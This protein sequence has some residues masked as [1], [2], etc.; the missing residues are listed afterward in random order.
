MQRDAADGSAGHSADIVAAMATLWMVL[1]I[2]SAATWQLAALGGKT[3]QPTRLRPLDVADLRDTRGTRA[4]RSV[5]WARIVIERD[6]SYPH[7]RWTSTRPRL[8]AIHIDWIS[9]QPWADDALSELRRRHAIRHY[10]DLPTRPSAPARHRPAPCL[11]GR[12]FAAVLHAGS[13][14]CMSRS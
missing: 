1:L 4:R 5:G 7:G 13:P 3:R 6:S 10:R 2:P 8:L 9:E 11:P 14:S 12:I